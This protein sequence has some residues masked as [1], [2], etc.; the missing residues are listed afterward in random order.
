[1]GPRDARARRTHARRPRAFESS[2]VHLT[3]LP[4]HHGGEETGGEETRDEEKTSG[5]E[6]RQE[7]RGEA[8]DRGE[9]DGGEEETRGEEETGRQEESR[10][11]EEAGGEEETRGEKETR[12]QEETGGEEETR[13][14]E[15]ESQGVQKVRRLP[16]HGSGARRARFRTRGGGDDYRERRFVSWV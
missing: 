16:S 15:A 12:S 13:G 7:A 14:Q 2:N 8:R 1:M 10:G 9:E 3:P 4:S 6:I 11:E 5:Q